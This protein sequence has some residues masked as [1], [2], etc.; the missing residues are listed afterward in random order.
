MLETWVETV[1]DNVNPTWTVEPE[2][3]TRYVRL[4]AEQL[5][6]DL[7]IDH[8]IINNPDGT[9]TVFDPNVT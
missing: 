1:I 9:I 5:G 8:Y 6:R 7:E 4:D 2:S 3:W